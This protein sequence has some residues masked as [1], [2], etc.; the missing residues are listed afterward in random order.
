MKESILPGAP[1]EFI[2]CESSRTLREAW[3]LA[4]TAASKESHQEQIAQLNLISNNIKRIEE[5]MMDYLL[6]HADDPPFI[7]HSLTQSADNR[8]SQ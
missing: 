5:Q 8:L 3:Y 4:K 7:Y 2:L 6:G 1:A